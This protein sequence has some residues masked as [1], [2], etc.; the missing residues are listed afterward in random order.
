MAVAPEDIVELP[1]GARWNTRTNEV[2]AGEKSQQPQYADYTPEGSL[3]SA[4]GAAKQFSWG[5]NAGLF[6]APD[7]VVKKFAKGAFGLKEKDAFQFADVYKSVAPETAPRNSVER[8][9]KTI[10]E[11]IGANLGISGILKFGVA[12][13]G[14]LAA[15]LAPN[16]GVIK[17]IAKNIL[18]D[19]R[20]NPKKVFAQDIKW[21]ILSGGTEAAV[22]ESLAPGEEKSFL[23][24]VAPAVVPL[25]AE[26]LPTNLVR[27]GIGAAKN[28]FG[29][30]GEAASALTTPGAGSMAGEITQ[31]APSLMKPALNLIAQRAEGQA[32][33]ALAPLQAGAEGN[34]P[35]IA[36]AMA[37]SQELQAMPEFAG[38]NL[39]AAQSSLYPPL[40]EAQNAAG[41]SLSGEGLASAS[42]LRQQQEEIFSN[43]I[44]AFAGPR[45]TLPLDQGLREVR[46]HLQQNEIGA[47]VERG[48]KLMSVPGTV[49]LQNH[50]DAGS[51]LR[52]TILSKKKDLDEE[53]KNLYGSINL[54]DIP[55][56]QTALSEGENSLKSVLDDA[57]NPSGGRAGIDF[58]DYKLNPQTVESVNILRQFVPIAE[59]G[60]EAGVKEAAK[61]VPLGGYSDVV[62]RAVD[63]GIYAPDYLKTVLDI[64]YNG[65][66]HTRQIMETLDRA[67]RFLVDRIMSYG[68]PPSK[69][70]RS[71]KQMAESQRS[72]ELLALDSM[73]S[74]LRGSAEKYI[75]DFRALEKGSE[76]IDPTRLASSFTGLKKTLSTVEKIMDVGFPKGPVEVPV[77]K[78]GEVDINS[79][80]APAAKAADAATAEEPKEI[81]FQ[82]LD[83]A[84]KKL[85]AAYES[86]QNQTDRR[87]VQIL[88]E[89]FDDWMDN[90]VNNGLISANSQEALDTLKAARVARTKVG[91][92]FERRK[93]SEGAGKSMQTLL[94][95]K[96][97]TPNQVLDTIFGS[98]TTPTKG[99]AT[100]IASRLENL[101]GKDSPEY[102][103]LGQAAYLRAVQDANGAPRAAKDAAK[104]LDNLLTGR[105]S[106]FANSVYTQQQKE[107]LLKLRG[108]IAQI[109][110]D[111]L[112]SETKAL[113]N[114]ATRPGGDINTTIQQALK[115]PADMQSLVK[116]MGP[117]PERM[118]ALRRQVWDQLGM[119]KVATTPNGIGQF[120]Q[121]H[122]AALRQLYS[123]EELNR[124]RALSDMQQRVFATVR[125]AGTLPGAGGSAEQIN[126]ALGTTP[127]SLSAM[128][129]A[130]TQGRQ[131]P[132]D[133]ATV[134]AMR[135]LTRRQEDVY[136][137][138]MQRALTDPDYAKYLLTTRPDA[139]A[140]KDLAS[141]AIT[142]VQGMN[143]GTRIAEGAGERTYRAIRAFAED[144]TIGEQERARELTLPAA[145]EV[146]QQFNRPPPTARE[147]LM[148][149]PQSKAPATTG[150]QNVMAPVQGFKPQQI[151]AASQGAAKSMNSTGMS[152]QQM[153]QA[154]F[155]RDS[156]SRMLPPGQ[157]GQPPR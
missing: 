101:F 15:D 8:Y 105:G 7:W 147:L 78:F 140:L 121:A 39:T 106:E 88:R 89:R 61:M 3:D 134:L 145:P 30:A 151:L 135:F 152:S 65:A 103:D 34:T 124:M 1:G 132:L 77:R 20:D 5:L 144:Q 133:I 139:Q 43:A 62:K 12:K 92:I 155:P 87:G 131:G 54:R 115:N 37:R 42:Q 123:P 50:L 156:L 36:A 19:L 64:R 108:D 128:L 114:K 111:T 32:G 24:S 33:R 6:A 71:F 60:A 21:G 99:V 45:P 63:E 97:L 26:M 130:Y 59:E 41:R 68:M 149:L 67:D 119:D 142:S 100:E 83:V 79:I 18:D 76:R 94:N 55:I 40:M 91:D 11:G 150:V 118:V 10:G 120:M 109:S 46:D 51:R 48:Q 148:Q 129:N 69:R 23:Q 86:A 22:N 4:L 27:K 28:A 13:T 136:A 127:R 84:R 85:S 81:F 126:S 74:G 56:T 16:A 25:A 113:L 116:L 17:K 154:L 14:A 58:L 82:D 93:G 2:V 80:G 96:E 53:V 57:L 104:E 35:E 47:L 157:P 110:T 95:S 29:Q 31:N 90:A 38:T 146:Q 44:E 117:D 9:A 52:D 137:R 72:K 66:K 141:G 107:A 73:L 143:L 98:N 112:D 102:A 122:A 75:N 153:Y 49:P 138:V 125:P 70:D